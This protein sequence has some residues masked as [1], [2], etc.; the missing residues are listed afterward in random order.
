M[1]L[2]NFGIKWGLYFF[3]AIILSPQLVEAIEIH[4]IRWGFSNTPVAYK[5][6][7]IT[8]LVENTK[9]VPFESEFIFQ[10]E[11]FR[12]QQIDITLSATTYVAPFE[13]KWIQFY[14]YF[15]ESNSNWKA[16]WQN[17]TKQY[18]QSFLSPAPSKNRV[19]VQL[20]PPNSL[21]RVIPGIKQYPEDLFPPFVGAIDS[22]DGII[23]DHVPKWEK[24][25]RTAF[26]Q[27]IFT[28]GIVHLFENSNGDQLA[29]PESFSP[30]NNT[31][32]LVHYGSG[33]IYRHHNRLHDLAPLELKQLIMKNNRSLENQLGKEEEGAPPQF[34]N[35]SYDQFSTISYNPLSNDEEILA[36]LNDISKP[37][38]IWYFIFLLSFIYL[39]V[40]GPGYYLITKLSKKHYTFYSVY[41]LSTA[42]FCFIFLIIGQH[43]ANR[44][45][46]IHSLIIANILPENEI[47]ITEWSNL[48]IASGGDFTISHVGDSHIY[49]TCQQYSKVN[50]VVTCGSEG[51]MQVDIPTNSS[52][53]Y[54]HR[55]KTSE[56]IF[57]VKI[58]SFLSNDQGLEELSLGI[59][60]NFPQKVDQ[61]HFLYG[62][63]LYELKKEKNQLEFHGTSRNLFS[64][65]RVNPLLDEY[66]FT[67][68]GI[69]SFVRPQVRQ[70]NLS[71]INL[72]PV[73]LQRVLKL[74]SKEQRLKFRLNE[75]Q[76]KLLVFSSI[77]AS[78]FPKSPDISQKEGL[79][80]YCLDVP[81]SDR[82]G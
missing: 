64:V 33:I 20:V 14:P 43:S 4:D 77:P 82:A 54:F 9:S 17:G 5:I 76:G 39:I 50:G 58:N 60:N 12:G 44:T 81:L 72:S 23:L 11:T 40:A 15:T 31:T 78:L 3:T 66:N 68:K 57:D 1:K 37:K 52:R 70:S 59:D 63:K 32:S 26:I 71:L 53:T 48:G 36:T 7:P 67:P 21:S 65:L 8:I 2:T 34:P 56:T 16:S 46:K 73:L 61:I 27:W 10:Q 45:S 80:L 38:Q 28:G 41:I 51:S 25:R 55:G 29:F 79:I 35:S 19:T 47:D 42:F 75:N 74:S 62:A 24:S 30:L 18:T 13:K 6:N 22:L 49:A 69:N